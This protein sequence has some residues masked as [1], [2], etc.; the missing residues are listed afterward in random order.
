MR[1]AKFRTVWRTQTELLLLIFASLLVSACEIIFPVPDLRLRALCSWPGY[2]AQGGAPDPPGS[3]TSVQTRSSADG[4]T[5]ETK[6]TKDADGKLIR[7]I[8]TTTRANS[9]RIE[10]TYGSR[11]KP[12]RIAQGRRNSDGSVWCS[13]KSIR[14]GGGWVTSEI[15]KTSRGRMISGVVTTTKPNGS[16]LT[17]EETLYDASGLPFKITSLTNNPDGSSVTRV[18]TRNADGSVTTVE[19]TRNPQG[20]IVRTLTAS[21]RRTLPAAVRRGTPKVLVPPRGLTAREV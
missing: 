5:V 14:I 13:D 16:I 19:T 9:I 6:I 12:S 21:A 11:T 4:S 20:E 7:T 18:T 2:S 3:T 17:R 15:R 1:K 8:V 10:E